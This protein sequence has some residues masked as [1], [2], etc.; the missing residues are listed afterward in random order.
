VLTQDFSRPGLP[1]IALTT[2]SSILTASANDFGFAGVFE[3]QVQALARPGDVVIG[4]STSGNSENTLRALQF[5]AAHGIHTVALTG[6]SGGK[7][8]AAAEIAIRIPSRSTAHIQ[9][10]QITVGHILCAIVER[11][12]FPE[13]L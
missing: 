11:S 2:D 13:K 10:A 1:A 7:M 8:A 3:R 4:I 12:L 9:E 6:A 5:A